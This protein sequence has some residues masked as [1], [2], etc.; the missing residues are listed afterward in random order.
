MGHKAS[1][2]TAEGTGLPLDVSKFLSVEDAARARQ[3][4]K[5]VY[6]GSWKVQH[7]KDLLDQRLTE[8]AQGRTTEHGT[9]FDHK[10]IKDAVKRVE[11]VSIP[12]FM[13]A[14]AWSFPESTIRDMAAKIDLSNSNAA[15]THWVQTEASEIFTEKVRTN[16]RTLAYAASLTSNKSLMHLIAR[17]FI[18][19]V[20]VT[21]L[22]EPRENPMVWVHNAFMLLPR[23]FILE[24]GEDFHTLV[25]AVADKWREWISSE[26]EQVNYFASVLHQELSS[27]IGAGV[28]AGSSAGDDDDYDAM[29]D[30]RYARRPRTGGRPMY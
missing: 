5:H 24:I 16:V 23:S 1:A 30:S 4:S 8:V 29:G 26:I 6:S 9:W 11:K 17:L 22:L 13:Q 25:D 10:A 20:F 2:L 21:Y 19:K 27:I 15:L 7:H 3:V 28:G 12:V 14:L 18:E